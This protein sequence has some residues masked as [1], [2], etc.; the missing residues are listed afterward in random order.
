MYIVLQKARRKDARSV[1]IKKDTNTVKFKIRCSRVSV[2]LNSGVVV[3][4][5]EERG[6]EME[7]NGNVASLCRS[8]LTVAVRLL[9]PRTVSV[10]PLR[11]R[12]RE[13]RQVDPVA[14]PW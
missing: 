3:V 12:F 14:S 7:Q 5:G 6:E 2:R 9:F 4:G 10:H 1:K 11:Y 13:G 8:A